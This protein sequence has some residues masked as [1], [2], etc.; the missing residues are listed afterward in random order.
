MRYI[1]VRLVSKPADNLKR[2]DLSRFAVGDVIEAPGHTAL[3]LMGE[4]WAVPMES[5]V[6]APRDISRPSYSKADANPAII[7][8]RH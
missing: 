4:G 1:P 8:P 2:F 6:L 3:M 5:A 7:A